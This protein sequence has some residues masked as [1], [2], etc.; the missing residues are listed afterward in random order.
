[1]REGV[2]EG[3]RTGSGAPSQNN[4]NSRR[5]ESDLCG[6]NL[7]VSS[8]CV[9]PAP[10]EGGRKGAERPFRR[11]PEVGRGR[12]GDSRVDKSASFLPLSSGSKGVPNTALPFSSTRGTFPAVRSFVSRTSQSRALGHLIQIQPFRSA[13]SFEQKKA[14]EIG[15]VSFIGRGDRRGNGLGCV[16]VS[17]LNFGPCCQF[18]A[19]RSNRMTIKL[20]SNGHGDPLSLPFLPWRMTFFSP[21]FMVRTHRG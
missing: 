21:H 14:A 12:F 17:L 5:V 9:T 4:W 2:R 18:L 8:G 1:M 20:F 19:H 6:D 7:S 10:M 15:L 11:L 13:I 3:G 16:E